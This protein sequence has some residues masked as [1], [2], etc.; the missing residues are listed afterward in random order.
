M[1]VLVLSVMLP[2]SPYFFSHSTIQQEEKQFS[3]L[4][5]IILWYM[6]RIA[7]FFYITVQQTDKLE[8]WCL[9]SEQ[10]CSNVMHKDNYQFVSFSSLVVVSSWMASQ[11]KKNVNSSL[12]K[13]E[14]GRKKCMQRRKIS[15]ALK[16][17]SGHC[18]VFSASSNHKTRFWKQHTSL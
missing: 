17:R 6:Y 12:S 1:V 11:L 18:W 16:L 15:I 3:M 2:F 14:A 8:R 13:S 5:Y 9:L 7:V 10:R 4:Y